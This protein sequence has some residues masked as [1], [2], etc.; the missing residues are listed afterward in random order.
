MHVAGDVHS[1]T[2]NL[3]VIRAGATRLTTLGVAVMLLAA[4][5]TTMTGRRQLTLID[6]ARMD[7]LGGA[8][9]TELK[10][11][12]TVDRDPATGEYVSCVADAILAVVPKGGAAPRDGNW[13][14]LVFDDASPNAFALPG[15]KIGVH[16]GMLDVASTAGQLAAVVGHE[17]AHVLLRHGNERLSQSTIAQNA[18]QA[19]SLAVGM[20]RPEYHDALV[21]G[22]GV[23][24][25]Y[26]VLL[27]FSRKHETEADTVGQQFMA[28][29]GFNP[30]EAVRL[31]QKMAELSQG[32][33]PPEWMSTHPSNQ[34]RIQN[35][36][37]RLPETKELYARARIAG[38]T[39]R[40]APPARAGAR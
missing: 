18:M 17:I 25:Q 9:F 4:C 23:G 38:K 20:T 39:P 31:W 3:G 37:A 1:D 5:S 26:G 28:R 21:G 19:G 24:A 14:V 34:S 32:Q 6:D 12:G 8:A 10:Q 30:T 16:T 11:Q 29:A 33:A 35:L 13:E 22:L 40:C 2:A 27:P 36:E 15:G 7:E